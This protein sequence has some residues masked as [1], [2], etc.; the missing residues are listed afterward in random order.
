MTLTLPARAYVDVSA[1]D[2]ERHA[3][4]AR[5][6]QLLGPSVQLEERGAYVAAE[7]AGWPVF[8]VRT[9]SDELRAFH[10]VCPHRAGVIVWPGTGVTG[11]LVC[12]Y[13][14]WAF[15]W[16]GT[17][18]RARDFGDDTGLCTGGE[19][20]APIQVESWRGLVWI[21]LDPSAPPLVEALG[22][23]VEECARFPMEQ[24][25][26][27]HRLVR[28]LACNWKTYADN[29]LEGY[30][31]PMLHPGLSRS[32][33]MSTYRVDVPEDGYC[34]HRAD[35]AGGSPSAGLWLFRYPNVALNVYAD[36]MNVE[37]IVPIDVRRTQI[38]Y[39]YFFADDIPAAGAAMVKM[40]NV[41]LDEDQ[42]ICEAVQRNLEAGVYERGTLSPKH[43]VGVA[44]FQ[45]RVAV[46]VGEA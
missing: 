10:N 18:T 46:A 45:R 35:T 37:R 27:G 21:T 17:L 13:H 31:V 28:Q 1:Y 22:G 3:I 42:A 41:V 20:L 16:D 14:G 4:W 40:S 7:I 5:E 30:H 24:F 15:G 43:E 32:L 29:Y 25:R 9:P 8:V 2:R 6:W 44:W 38:V 34:V 19:R 26:H 23:F 39:D 12:R 36:G 11:N 33:D